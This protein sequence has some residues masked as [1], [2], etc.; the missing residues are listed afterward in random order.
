MLAQIVKTHDPNALAEYIVERFET[1]VSDD[2]VMEIM[3]DLGLNFDSLCQGEHYLECRL[4]NRLR[5]RGY[6]KR[7]FGDPELFD[8]HRVWNTLH[9]PWENGYGDQDRCKQFSPEYVRSRLGECQEVLSPIDGN[10]AMVVKKP[11]QKIAA[12][13]RQ[14]LASGQPAKFVKTDTLIQKVHNQARKSN[15]WARTESTGDGHLLVW[16][17]QRES[18]QPEG[19]R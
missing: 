7:M 6:F 17:T 14:A 16:V 11:R 15:C 4:K 10:A 5:E 2:D 1:I 18:T 12:A 13:M 3:F 19:V 9:W 8:V